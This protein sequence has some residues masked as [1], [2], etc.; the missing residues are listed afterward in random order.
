MKIFEQYDNPERALKIW[1][2]YK[3]DM[4]NEGRFQMALNIALECK[5]ADSLDIKLD[6]FLGKLL[7]FAGNDAP[8]L[9][10]IDEDSNG[11]YSNARRALEE[12]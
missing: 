9:N 11:C 3:E 10:D 12:N 2:A 4:T 7:H 1:E 5:S 8:S 6:M